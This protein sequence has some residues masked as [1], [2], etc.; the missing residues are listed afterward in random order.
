M[1]V[2]AWINEIGV[3]ADSFAAFLE[4]VVELCESDLALHRARGE[5]SR[6]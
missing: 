3:R 5:S 2:I 1:G 6:Q 4:T